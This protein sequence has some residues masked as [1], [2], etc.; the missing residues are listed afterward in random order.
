MLLRHSKSFLCF[1]Y[2]SYCLLFIWHLLGEKENPSIKIDDGNQVEKKKLKGIFITLNPENSSIM[3]PPHHIFDETSLSLT[4]R[5]N[6]EEFFNE[7]LDVYLLS[8]I[9]LRQKYYEWHISRNSYKCLRF[10]SKFQ[11]VCLLILHFEFDNKSHSWFFEVKN[12]IF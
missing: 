2:I 7:I 6:H 11:N 5:S 8:T 4:D 10:H 9:F 12:C 1:Y 3:F